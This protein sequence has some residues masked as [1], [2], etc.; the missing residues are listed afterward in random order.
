MSW[1]RKY[2]CRF[3]L[4]KKIQCP[5]IV[6]IL[7]R[8][9]IQKTYLNIIQVFYSESIANITL[10]EDKVKAI[11]LKSVK[12]QCCPFSP[13]VFNIAPDILAREITQ[14]KEIKETQIGNKEVKISLFAYDNREY[15]YITLKITWENFYSLKTHSAKELHTK[16]THKIS[17]PLT[18]K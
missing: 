16:L 2:W 17:S 7:E 11:P 13:H 10:N 1:C 14:L 8:L 18:Y 9:G 12:R 3:C 5:L 6:K 15:T 4:W